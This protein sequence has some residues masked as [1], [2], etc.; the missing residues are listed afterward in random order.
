MSVPFSGRHES[1]AEVLAA[2][3]L[4]IRLLYTVVLGAIVYTIGFL[5]TDRQF[6]P[7][8]GIFFSAIVAGIFVLPLR[9][10]LQL[11]MPRAEPQSRALIAGVVLMVP[12]TYAALNLPTTY[13]PHG[14]IGF[15]LF[16]VVYL[17]TLVLAQFWAADRR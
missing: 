2:T 7:I 9:L 5:T 1:P 4:M 10:L 8:S 3:N 12:V 16:W 17:S 15:F 11:F 14:R 6:L 13:L